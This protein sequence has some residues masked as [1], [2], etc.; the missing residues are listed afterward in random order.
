MN[1][2]SYLADLRCGFRIAPITHSLFG[3]G[4]F[5]GK[6]QQDLRFA[7]R[8]IVKNPGF[9]LTA[10]LSLALGIGATVSVFSVIYDAVI[11]AWPYAGFDRVCQI[12][13]VSKSGEEGPAGL[14]GPEIRQLRQESTV[15]DVLAWQ[16]WNLIV[17]GSDVPEDV[18]GVYFSGNGFPFLAMPALLGRY[19]LPSDAP[20]HLDPQPVAVLG[21]KFWER[22]F[23]ADPNIV[24][25]NIQLVHKDYTI[26]GVMPPR[27]TWGDGE[28][29]LPFRMSDSPTVFYGTEVKLKPGISTAAAEAE[30]T[31]FFQEIDRNHPN[32]FP[33][34]FRLRVRK[35]GD[36][37]VR[38]LRGTL[39]LLLAAVALLLA[40]GCC[41]VSILLLARGTAR[42]HEFAIRSAIGATRLRIVRQLLTES[43]LLAL[44]GA[45]WGVILAYRAVGFIVARLPEY[46]YPHEADFHVNLPV[47]GFSV[48]L[49]I[50]SG[51]LFGIFP[52]CGVARREVNPSI[53]AGSH[54]L[55][56]TVRGKQVH[57]GLIVGQIALTLLLLTAAGAAIQGFERMMKRPLGY[58]P[59]NVMSVGIPVHENTFGRWA[60]R[61]AYFAQLRERVAAMP[62]VVEAGISTNATPPSNGWLQP[63]EILG[64]TAG[65][66]QEALINF[67]SPEY[68]TILRIPLVQGRVWQQ[69]EI[70]RG[71]TLAVV[72]Q[73]FIRRYLS[74]EDAL[75]HSLRLP[76][77]ISQPPNR[78][79][80][81]GSDGWL[82]V[83]GVV[84]DALDDG[85]DKPIKPAIYLPYTLNMWMWTQ[86]LV[87]TQGPPL[88]ILHDVQK[89]IASVNP[90]QQVE[91]RATSLE[92][93]IARET[94]WARARLISILFIAFS[95]LALTLA[96]VG[97]YSVVSYSVVQR[98]GEF[99][100]RLAL[101]AQRQDVLRIVLLSAGASV[102]LG[103]AF[104]T[105]LSLG[106]GRVITGWVGSGRNDPRVV[107]GV[108]LL[109]FAIA[110]LAC[111]VPVLRAID[112]NPMTALRHE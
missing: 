87:R 93:W 107:L 31:P 32:R 101:G 1:K 47:L 45:G 29:Y 97:L 21:Y 84:V 104:G 58:D 95:G 68:F 55:A 3:P 30:F 96:G 60:Q 62:G 50:L 12:N 83:I 63:F 64:K 76:E 85:M 28:V 40:V 81:A 39:N 108:S 73:T 48:G 91:S 102:G 44:V 4:A 94:E 2:I 56:G 57:S 82:Q 80:V 35:S 11:H 103:L 71:A 110:A 27:F 106:M 18:R 79:T 75:G 53:Q 42:Q 61:A 72:N 8:Q 92:N 78:V 34:H 51:I 36:Y 109:V 16:A 65:E 13:A 5:M 33:P 112:V 15:E 26:L 89:Q 59:H 6:L 52:A 74:G 90:D 86:I 67:V 24:G 19:F 22:H 46:S 38:D 69:G 100:I 111:V 88:A 25:K 98:T 105:A 10:I 23:N 99:G 66:Q 9:S 17:T 70:N 77:L 49:A 14:T 41:N 54:T 7:L 43:L 37:Y 20:D